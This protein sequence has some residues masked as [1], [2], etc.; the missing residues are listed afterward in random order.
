VFPRDYKAIAA[1]QPNFPPT[2]QDARAGASIVVGNV[3]K[4]LTKM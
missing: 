3:I 4:K 2:S 1:L